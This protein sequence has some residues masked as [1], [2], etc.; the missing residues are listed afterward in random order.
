MSAIHIIAEAGTNHGGNLETARKLVD[1]AVAA[2]A[3]SVK[4]QIIYP[5]GLYLT[6]VWQDGALRDNPVVAARR[7]QM[8]R[9]ED[10]VL[11]AAHARDRGIPFSA[12]VFDERGLNLLASLDPPFIKIASCDLNNH[13]LL[14]RAA[15][16]G[17]RLVVSTGMSTL[18]DVDAS[19]EVLRR[20]GARD[21][22]LL[23]C[24]SVYPCPTE[25]MNLGFID[26]LRAAFGLPVGFSDHSESSVAAAIAVAK[27][28]TW[29]EKH[30]TLDRKAEGF[31]HAY[32][33]EPAQLASYI[34]DVRAAEAACARP[35]SKL[36]DAERTVMQR[37]RRG[38]YAAR[39]LP[40][41]AAITPEDVLVV[42][43][44]GPLAPP[45]L[46]HVVGC[47]LR[48]ALRAHEPIELGQLG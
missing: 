44:E 28:A 1:A 11:L 45:D 48:R 9:D 26:T 42:R 38:L 13:P 31:D 36:G 27:G 5:E 15:A 47:R 46:R 18:A 16:T 2:K 14:A 30:F 22:V 4:F 32:A 19:V 35:A 24:V 6:K 37:A 25:A 21:V 20:E 23:H 17:K 3:D 39:D 8:L 10:Y 33:M 29:I 34:A 12:S 7:A 40:V 43:P 41:G